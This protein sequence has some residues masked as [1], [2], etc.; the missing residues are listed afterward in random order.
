ME[1]N[2]NIKAVLLPKL[3]EFK[4][5]QRKIVLCH[6]A[7]T[8][9]WASHYDSLHFHGHSHGKLAAGKNFRDVGVDTTNFNPILIDD[10]IASLDD[11]KMEEIEKQSENPE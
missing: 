7:M 2:A 4:Y 3:F 10:A 6:Y 8:K 5:N 9:W 1:E 11:A